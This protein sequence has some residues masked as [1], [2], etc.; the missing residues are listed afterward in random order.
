MGVV[1]VRTCDEEASWFISSFILLPDSKGD[2]ATGNIQW[3]R[4]E[5][6]SLEDQKALV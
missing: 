1:V 5:K 3:K 4:E 6:P 2:A